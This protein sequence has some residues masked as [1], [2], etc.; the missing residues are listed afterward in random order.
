MPDS[1]TH[2]DGGWENPIDQEEG[3][4]LSIHKPSCEPVDPKLSCFSR[5]TGTSETNLNGLAPLRDY[6]SSSFAQLSVS[7]K[8][9]VSGWCDGDFPPTTIRPA[10]RELSGGTFRLYLQNP[11]L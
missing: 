1:S 5:K 7:L 9:P 8:T 10:T 2:F 4:S 6:D 3:R 11:D